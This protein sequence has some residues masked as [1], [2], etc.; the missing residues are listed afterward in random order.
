ME[1]GWGWGS[2]DFPN[3]A[4]TFCCPAGTILRGRQANLAAACNPL[5]LRG[6]SAPMPVRHFS[7]RASRLP[8]KGLHGWVQPVRLAG[9]KAFCLEGLSGWT[10]CPSPLWHSHPGLGNRGPCQRG[11][12]GSQRAGGLAAPGR[13]GWVAS[14]TPGSA[15][16][17]DSLWPLTNGSWGSEEG[18]S[19]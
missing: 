5:P 16:K 12:G 13:R 2:V 8:R 4:G 10:R 11:K 15:S 6:L 14:L 1:Q 18:W 3:A 7:P 17:V 9:K 19:Q